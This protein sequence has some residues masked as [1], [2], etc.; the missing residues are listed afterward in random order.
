MRWLGR[1]TA[2][3]RVLDVAAG[4][5]YVEHGSLSDTGPVERVAVLAHYAVDRRVTRSFRTLVT[6]FADSGYLPLVIS[7]SPAP[8][9]L[10]WEGKLPAQAI[11]MRQPNVGY[12]F[13]SWAIGLDLLGDKKNAPWLILANDSVIGP[14]ASIAPLL[15]EFE[16]TRA[17]VWGLTDTYQFAHHLQSYFIGFRGGILADGPLAKFWTDVRVEKTKWDII[18]RN[19]LGLNRLLHNEGYS[20]TAAFP[21][22]T[23]VTGGDNPV[24]KGWWHLL[25]NGFPFVKR[26]I[27]V[28]PSVAPRS[29]WVAAEVEAVYGTHLDDWL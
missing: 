12:D 6:E 7:A 28:N 5:V 15:A 23:I 21:A 25:E 13:G 24:I 2:R 29:E 1:A 16:A 14:F 11:V 10:E 20:T 4:H 26:E 9:P 27:V 19:E 17:D 18:R 22:H 8:G 3:P